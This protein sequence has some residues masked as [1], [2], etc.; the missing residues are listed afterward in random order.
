MAEEVKPK[1]TAAKTKVTEK[2]EVA[3][4]T[5]PVKEAV[6]AKEVKPE[7]VVESKPVVAAP[8]TPVVEE[9]AED[10][11]DDTMEAMS[12]RGRKAKSEKIAEFAHELGIKIHNEPHLENLYR[13]EY[14]EKVAKL[15]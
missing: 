14:A 9:K 7:P 8:P 11:A 10:S 15:K 3:E 12:R 2:A 13:A 4:V 6:V 1:P 5:A